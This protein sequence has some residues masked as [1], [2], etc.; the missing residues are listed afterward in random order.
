MSESL[1]QSFKLELFLI[2]HS[3]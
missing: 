3:T 2:D 1:N